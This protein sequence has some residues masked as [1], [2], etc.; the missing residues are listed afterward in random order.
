M[1]FPVNWSFHILEGERGKKFKNKNEKENSL[2]KVYGP[3]IC[4][5][6]IYYPSHIANN[7]NNKFNSQVLSQ[8][9]WK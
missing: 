9:I 1:G 3:C 6:G 5:F 4:N 8:H 2:D 7:N